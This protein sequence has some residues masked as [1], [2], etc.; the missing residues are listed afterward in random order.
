MNI[1]RGWEIYPKGIYDFG[2]KMK[3]EYPNLKFFVSEMVWV[4]NMNIASAMK[5]VKFKMIIVL[6]LLKNI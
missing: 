5:Q 4:L 3:K 6:N 1:Y 2:M